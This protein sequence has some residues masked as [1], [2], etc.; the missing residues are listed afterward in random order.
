MA[1]R[2]TAVTAVTNEPSAGLSQNPRYKHTQLGFT[3]CGWLTPDDLKR[4]EAKLQ[5]MVQVMRPLQM[6]PVRVQ[7][8]TSV[9]LFSERC[10]LAEMRKSR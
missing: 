9:N 7:W 10:Q 4:K 3:Q 8:S 5:G 2:N 6:A 1:I